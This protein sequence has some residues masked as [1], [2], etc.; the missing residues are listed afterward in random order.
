[1]VSSEVEEFLDTKKPNTRASYNSG[2]RMFLSYYKGKHGEAATLSTFL[3]RLDENARLSRRERKRLAESELN[4]FIDYL[5]SADKSSKTILVYFSAVQNFLKYHSFI[6]S[7]R[8][9]RLPPATPK[10]INVKHAWK[11]EELKEFVNTAT[12]IRDKAIILC[13]F[14]SGLSISDLCNLNYGDVMEELD[15]RRLPLHIH[16]YRQKTGEE[17]KTFFGRDA[18]KYLRLYLETRKTLTRTSPL[19]TMSGSNTKRLTEGAIQARFRRIVKDLS[20][21]KEYELAGF[22]PCRP[23]SL[24]SAFRSRLTGKMDQDL[25]EF[26]MGHSLGGQKKAYINLPIDEL[27]EL[28]SNYE[29]LL[30]FEKT[31]KDEHIEEKGESYRQFEKKITGFE[32]TINVLS[33]KLHNQRSRIQ[34]LEEAIMRMRTVLKD[35]GKFIKEFNENMMPIIEDYKRSKAFEERLEQADEQERIRL[36]DEEIEYTKKKLA[37]AKRNAKTQKN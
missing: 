3:D 34:R 21:I 6:V 11:L 4:G 37:E 8:F 7:A 26:M 31:S 28:Y 35:C 13:L 12:N 14:Q 25:I 16:M 29:Y 30:T 2:L 1:M 32:T 23:H 18:I 15:E 22:N 5:A 17:F 20:F 27:R 24:R 9:L 36:L 19:F 10:K 33:D